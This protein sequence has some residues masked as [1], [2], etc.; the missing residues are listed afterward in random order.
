MLGFHLKEC[1][2]NTPFGSVLVCTF[3]PPLLLHGSPWSPL[4]HSSLVH[5]NSWLRPLPNFRFHLGLFFYTMIRLYMKVK[6]KSLSR[7]RPS[8]TPWTADFQAPPSV[9]F[10]RQEYWSGVPLPSPIVYNT[11]LI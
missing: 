2:I 3:T 9:G 8:G 5:E 11:D 6:V 4:I 1:T 7:F 10:S